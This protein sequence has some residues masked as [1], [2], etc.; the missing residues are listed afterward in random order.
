MKQAFKDVERGEHCKMCVPDNLHFVW[1]GAP[2]RLFVNYINI[3]QQVNPDR[4][5]QLWHDAEFSLCADFGN[6][7][8]SHARRVHGAGAEEQECALKNAAFDFIFPR[9]IEGASLNSVSKEFLLSHGIIDEGYCYQ[10]NAFPASLSA[11][12]AIKDVNTLFK[13]RFT[14]YVKYYC[15]ETIIRGNLASASDLIR[16][17]VLYQHGGVYIDIDTLPYLDNLFSRTNFFMQ[18]RFIADNQFIALAKTEAALRKIDPQHSIQAGPLHHLRYIAKM[19]ERTKESLQ[20]NI[21]ADADQ[22][23]LQKLLPLGKVCTYKNFLALG[24]VRRLK[25]IYYNNALAASPGAKAISI[26]LRSL[27]KRYRYLE[28]NNAIVNRLDTYRND[29]YLS[30]LL[31]WREEGYSHHFSVTPALSG[32]GLIMEVL[33]ALAYEIIDVEDAMSPARIA[34]YMHNDGFGVA[35]FQHTLDTPA[36]LNSSWRKHY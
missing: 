22:I 15:Y 7:I 9:L 3:W 36:G 18:E 6:I 10:P 16:L 23:N 13:G 24:A 28:K 11:G 32:P 26:I 14:R 27:D 5:C 33:L 1:L 30:R 21:A 29:H 34:E 35:F 17:L 31:P 20:K 2:E 25:G 12:I 19:S 8:S 4:R